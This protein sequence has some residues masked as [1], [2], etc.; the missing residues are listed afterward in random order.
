MVLLSVYCIGSLA[1]QSGRTS[2]GQWE[3]V[4]FNFVLPHSD[5][6]PFDRHPL[7]QCVGPDGRQFAVPAYYTGGNTYTVR[8][9][10]PE[11]GDWTVSCQE[12]GDAWRASVSRADA[13]GPGPV[14]IRE[15]NPQ[16]FYYANGEPCFVLAFEADWLFALDLEVAGYERAETLLRDIKANGFN[17]V[18][19]NVYA[20]DTRWANDPKLPAKYDFARPKQWPYGGDNDRP[21]YSR[22]NLEFFAH[23]DGIIEMMNELDLTAHIMIYVWNKQVNWPASDSVEDNRYFDYVVARYQAYPNII[24]DISKEA[25]GYGHN[26]MG[27]IVR[28]IERLRKMDGHERLVTVHSFSYCAKYPETVDF[29]SYQNWSASLYNRMLDTY[30]EFTDKPIFNIE[31]GGYE[32]GPYHVFD[33]DYDD[34]VACLDR[35]Y[36]CVFGGTYSTYYWQDTSWDI[37]IWDKSDLPE[38]QRPRYDLYR[39]MAK[40]FNDVDY[41]AF[42]PAKERRGS[43]GYVLESEDDRYLFYLPAANKRINTR[44]ESHYG[45]TM[46]ARWFNPLTGEYSEET[47]PVMEQWLRFEP[48]WQGQPVIL[49]LEP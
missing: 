35:N 49:I 30:Q 40:L 14:V 13:N 19:M 8:I 45:K 4:E 43:S 47:N 42:K 48:P 20:H 3:V 37:V 39:H 2:A 24:W 6:N 21:D 5:A 34:S 11:P 25:T 38:N 16:H 22:M 15:D 7:A 10:F 32:I 12:T 9:S 29:I 46:R 17:Q 36:Q 28:R 18:V 41:T 27:Y 26:D 33:G 1:A 31:H 44:I 23:F